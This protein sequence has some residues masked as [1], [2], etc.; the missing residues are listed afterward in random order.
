[1]ALAAQKSLAMSVNSGEGRL[2]GGLKAAAIKAV[3]WARVMA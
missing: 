2:A 3:Y 1:M